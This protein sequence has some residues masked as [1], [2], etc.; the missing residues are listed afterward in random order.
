MLGGKCDFSRCMN[1]SILISGRI[2]VARQMNGNSKQVVSNQDGPHPDLRAVVQKHFRHPYI[3]PSRAFSEQII[4]P[5]LNRIETHN[6]NVILDSG[7]GT[8]ESTVKLARLHPDAL[9]I[10]IDKSLERINETPWD[11]KRKPSENYHILRGDLVDIWRLLAQ[12]NIRLQH[13]FLLYPNPW[14]KK[15]H[16]LR[17]WYAHPAF[18][19]ILELGGTLH[20]RTN[21]EV[22]AREFAIALQ[23]AGYRDIDCHEFS[24]SSPLTPFERKY[25]ASGHKL[26]ALE[27]N[28][29]APVI[30]GSFAD[31][32]TGSLTIRG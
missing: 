1:P 30:N 17:R 11:S 32:A 8:G 28:L 16:L 24:T 20:L 22:Y 31:P 12:A 9:V 10:G 2:P 7:C 27:I 5:L 29:N 14:P 6:G 3:A 18:P 23:V 19:H 15:K 26:F 13:H 25:A 4:T 21:W